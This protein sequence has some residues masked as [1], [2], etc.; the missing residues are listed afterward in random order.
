M[1]YKTDGD[2]PCLYTSEDLAELASQARKGMTQ[3]EVAD[4]LDV[5][6]QSISKAENRTTGSRMN[7]LRIR[8]IEEIGGHEVEGP[9]WT[10]EHDQRTA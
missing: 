10:I 6:K 5:T 7:G 4:A 8:I 9:Y 3:K 2:E 1:G